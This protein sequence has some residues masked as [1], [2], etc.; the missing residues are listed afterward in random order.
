MDPG[1]ASLSWQNVMLDAV[2]VISGIALI[3]GLLILSVAFAKD[4]SLRPYRWY[5]LITP[6]VILLAG[7]DVG[8]FPAGVLERLSTLVI[9]IW[10]EVVAFRLLRL[11]FHREPEL[12]V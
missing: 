4:P 3:P 6:F 12:S 7:L 9:M 5:T 2:Y 11:A 1:A 10:F 8:I